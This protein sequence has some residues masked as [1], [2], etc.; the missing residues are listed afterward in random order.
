MDRSR[1]QH[2]APPHRPLAGTPGGRDRL[3]WW[4]RYEDEGVTGPVNFNS[5]SD[6]A[7]AVAAFLV[8]MLTPGEARGRPY[9]MP[10]PGDTAPPPP[11]RRCGPVAGPRASPPR[12]RPTSS[13]TSPPSCAW[14]SSRSRTATWTPPPCRSTGCSTAPRRAPTS[15][16]RRGALAPA[17]PRHRPDTRRRLGGRVRHRPGHRPRRRPARPARR[18][19]RPALRP[20]LRGHLTQRHPPLLLHRLPEPRQDRRFPC[21]RR[22]PVSGRADRPRMARPAGVS[23]LGDGPRRT[24]AVQS[25]PLSSVTRFLATSP[26]AAPGDA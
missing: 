20:R 16:P 3:G 26:V 4:S 1:R 19:H 21:P 7:V 17:L 10:P 8:N 24:P 18:L 22:P 14:S 9:T 2:P 23:D 12:P 13:P 15:T 25:A 5:H 6:T 11:P